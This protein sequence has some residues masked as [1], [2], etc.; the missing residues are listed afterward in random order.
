MKSQKSLIMVAFMF[1]GSLAHA[2]SDDRNDDYRWAASP[3]TEAKMIEALDAVDPII[4]ELSK[5]RLS[6]QN[7]LVMP[8]INK[9]LSKKESDRLMIELLSTMDQMTI[10]SMTIRSYLTQSSLN[11]IIK[12]SHSAVVKSD[13][14]TSDLVGKIFSKLQISDKSKTENPDELRNQAALNACRARN[15]YH[16]REV[17]ERPAVDT[18]ERKSTDDPATGTQS[19]EQEVGG[20]GAFT[21]IDPKNPPK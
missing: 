6:I 2:Q 5:K 11:N 18:S 7:D 21:A 9:A 19:N 14:L 17:G 10:D 15:S 16:S 8:A 4:R 1:L 13:K 3:V 12:F 20:P